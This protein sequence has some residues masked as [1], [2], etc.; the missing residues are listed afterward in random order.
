MEVKCVEL[1]IVGLVLSIFGQNDWQD[2]NI[3]CNSDF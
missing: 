2:L 1:G 3:L